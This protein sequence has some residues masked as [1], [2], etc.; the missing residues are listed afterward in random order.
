M[1]FTVDHDAPLGTCVDSYS[2]S[3]LG[4][5]YILEPI[6]VEGALDQLMEAINDYC[7]VHIMSSKQYNLQQ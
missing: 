2:I 4:G 7:N 1:V 5:N 6:N 3:K